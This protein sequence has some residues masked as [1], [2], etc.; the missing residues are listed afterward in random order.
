L[1]SN[2]RIVGPEP[3]NLRPNRSERANLHI[4]TSI[5]IEIVLFDADV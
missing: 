5:C 2:G 1:S 4:S 3:I